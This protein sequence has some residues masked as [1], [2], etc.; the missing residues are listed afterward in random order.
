MFQV[1]TLLLLWIIVAF[2]IWY[3]LLQLIPREYLTW[4]GGAILLSIIVLAFFFPTE[5]G[6][7]TLWYLLSFPLRPIGLCIVLLLLAWRNDKK[8][9][10]FVLATLIILLLCSIPWLSQQYQYWLIRSNFPI[11]AFCGDRPS[12]SSV[13]PAE[14]PDA[15][16]LLAEGI[17][18]PS[19]PYQPQ[20][21][22]ANMS[23]RIITAVRQY[24]L[25]RYRGNRPKVI[26]AARPQPFVWPGITAPWYGR[27]NI[28]E[29]AEAQEIKTMLLSLGVPPTDITILE[30]VD[31]V[32][33]S[34][35]KLQELVEARLLGDRIILVASALNLPRATLS[36]ESLGFE[37]IP[38]APTFDEEIC[39]P[40]NLRVDIYDVIPNAESFL[41]STRVVEEFYTLMYYFLRRWIDPCANCAA[42]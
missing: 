36:F 26:V 5:Q 13:P 31:N 41:R 6:V 30:D 25:Q 38:R 40:E 1:I 18:Q 19:I 15:I 22:E 33:Y 12:P 21:I 11:A 17:S 7:A 14:T 20:L 4:L 39:T 23:D 28:P 9:N 34:A 16:V 10:Q 27:A 8:R 2:L 3:V 35:E 29:V 24:Q 37:V 42:D 32:R